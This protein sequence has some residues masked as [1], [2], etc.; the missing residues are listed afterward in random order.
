MSTPYGSLPLPTVNSGSNPTND[1]ATPNTVRLLFENGWDG[2][3]PIDDPES[4]EQKANSLSSHPAPDVILYA[5]RGVGGD[6]ES[7]VWSVWTLSNASTRTFCYCL[8]NAW[9]GDRCWTKRPITPTRQR[10]SPTVSNVAETRVPGKVS[11]FLDDP[12]GFLHQIREATLRKG[13]KVIAQ[14]RLELRD[15]SNQANKKV[16]TEWI[17]VWGKTWSPSDAKS[18]SQ[19][20]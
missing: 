8:N 7:T 16:S 15:G 18:V 9:E 11:F 1:S 20:E 3:V 17:P 5:R 14:G 6:K 2:L 13:E 19:S 4:F 12:E 10:L